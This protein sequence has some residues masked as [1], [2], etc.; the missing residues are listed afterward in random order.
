MMPTIKVNEMKTRTNTNTNEGV[1]SAKLKKL[2]SKKY[3]IVI[4]DI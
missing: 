1:I 2:C 3:I 4:N